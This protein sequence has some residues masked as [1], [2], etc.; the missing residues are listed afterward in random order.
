MNALE[1]MTDLTARGI[2]LEAHSD[3]LRY[4]PRLALTPSLTERMKTHKPELL[5]IL[6]AEERQR[7]RQRFL[8]GMDEPTRAAFLWFDRTSSIKN[9]VD[10]IISKP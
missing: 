2:Q 5:A 8:D 4:S 3:R 6:A 9:Q 10:N 1:L 7:E